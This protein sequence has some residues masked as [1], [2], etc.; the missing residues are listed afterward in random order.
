MSWGK[1]MGLR[2]RTQA[3]QPEL[4]PKLPEFKLREAIRRKACRDNLWESN[5]AEFVLCHL[6]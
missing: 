1:G 5:Y 6:P 3:R 4:G 2:G